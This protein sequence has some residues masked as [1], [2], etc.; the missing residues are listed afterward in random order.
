ME[1]PPGP[2]PHRRQVLLAAASAPPLLA[3]A[4]TAGAAAQ[5]P[6]AQTPA[7]QTSAVGTPPQAPGLAPGSI[8]VSALPDQFDVEPGVHNLENGYWGIMPRP[9]DEHYVRQ[10]LFINRTNSIWARNVLTGGAC[11]SAGG[12]AAREAI[13]RQVGAGTDEI[14]ITRSGAE[15]L[16]AL[17]T[18]YRRLQA[19]D[20]VIC[21]DLDYDDMVASLEGLVT[22]RGVELVRFAMPEPATTANILAAYDAVL[23]RT[24]HARLLLVTQVSNKTGLVTPVRDIVAMARARGVDTV[25]DA[26]HG[27]ACLDFQIG[28]LGADFVGW[29]VHKW[30]SAPLGTG[31]M[32][33]RRE[34]LQDI[35]PAPDQPDPDPH[36]ITARTPAGTVDFA[37]VTTIPVAVDF[38]FAVGARAKEHHLRGLR[39]RWVQALRDTPEVEICVP[40]DPARY[41]AITSFRLKGM[42]TDAEA[43]ALQ[44][45]LFDRH[46]IHTIWRTGP[47]KGPVIRVTPGLYSR[48]EDVDA[49]A[50]AL[51]AERRMFL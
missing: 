25:V 19:G 6:A 18:Q 12:R 8:P 39:D 7:A 17:L 29:S 9:V 10:T 13:A 15:A 33:I 4:L 31:A 14:A 43:Q 1:N 30:T 48:P 26:A 23:T 16:N 11:L 3:G 47:A 42:A 35:D 27:V 36:D 37:A 44:K 51:R 40:D 50:A 28:D 32:Y 24:P 49:L 21:C 34:R 2:T 5:T 45:V 38:H 46:R 22:R 41:C 20:A